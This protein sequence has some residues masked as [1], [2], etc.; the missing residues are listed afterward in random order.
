MNVNVYSVDVWLELGFFNFMVE[1]LE[2]SV[3]VVV[4]WKIK[5]SCYTFLGF[6]TLSV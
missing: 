4:K 6:I 1:K 2:K 3:H 5:D